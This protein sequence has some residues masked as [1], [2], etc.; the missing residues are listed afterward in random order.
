[1]G[2]TIA[3]GDIHGDLAA[4]ERLFLRLPDLGSGDTLVFVGDYVDRGPHSREVVERLRTL[5]SRTAARVVA[6]RGNHEDAWLQVVR[7]GWP[8]FVLPRGNGCLEALRSFKGAPLPAVNDE[9]IGAELEELLRGSFFPPDVVAWME[10]LPHYYEDEHAIYVHAGLKRSGPE[11]PFPH[12]R[13]VE[14]KR[15]LLWLRDQ[16]FFRN[17]HGKLIVFGHTVTQ[18]LPTELSMYSPDDPT[19]LWA[20]ES[21]IGLDTGAGKGGFLTAVE[22]PSGRVFESR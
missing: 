1:M 10:S 15:S 3:I 21:A 22:L 6:L 13:E 16:D 19:D 11:A 9:P 20:G 7:S 2:R 14:P 8:D 17:Y 4:L 12:P 5:P 18:L